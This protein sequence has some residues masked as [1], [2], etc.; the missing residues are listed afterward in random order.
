MRPL[1]VPKDC[2]NSN[3]YWIIQM[4]NL[5]VYIPQ[6]VMCQ[7]MSLLTM[8]KGRLPWKVYILSKLARFGIKS[9]ELCEAKPGYV[10]NFIT[11]TG[12]GT[13][14]DESLKMSHMVQK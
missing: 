12:Q 5:G 1:A 13:I 2:I 11:Y 8:W 14:F 7:L 10:W 9:F 4:P 3:P 6:S